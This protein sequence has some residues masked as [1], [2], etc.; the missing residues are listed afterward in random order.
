VALG[1]ITYKDAQGVSRSISVDSITGGFAEL[2]KLAFSAAGADPTLVSSGNPLPITDAAAEATLASILA[3]LTADP[4]TQ[5]TLAAVLAKLSADPA[6][7]TTLAAIAASV[8]GLEGFTD[9]LEALDTAIR[10][11]LPS[12]LQGGALS[13]RDAGTFGYKAGA[14]AANVDV[15]TG[16]RIKRVTVLPGASAAATISILAGDTITVPAGSSFD[17]MIPGDAIAT[18]ATNEVAIGGTAQAYYVSWVV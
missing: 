9:G 12:A 18:S 8:D 10:D 17:E 16:A 13:I 5:T 15:P 14:A 2:L 11:R 1:F 4:A 7:Q 3:K 6:T